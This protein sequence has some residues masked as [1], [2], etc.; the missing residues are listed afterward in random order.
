M[1]IFEASVFKGNRNTVYIFL[2]NNVATK[3]CTIISNTQI[4]R[5]IKFSAKKAL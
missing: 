3:P 5:I 1:A 4:K 2:F